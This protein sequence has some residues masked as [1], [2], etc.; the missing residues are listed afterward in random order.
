[1]PGPCPNGRPNSDD[2]AVGA[3][4]RNIP[5]AAEIEWTSVDLVRGVQSLSINVEQANVEQMKVKTALVH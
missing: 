1:V 4:S 2:E 5:G 3:I